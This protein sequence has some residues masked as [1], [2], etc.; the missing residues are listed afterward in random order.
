[1][2]EIHASA[3]YRNVERSVM[4][5]LTGASL[6]APIVP[7]GDEKFDSSTAVSTGFVR[8]SFQP[9]AEQPQGRVVDS[10]TTLQ[11]VRAHILLVCEVFAQGNMGGRS[12]VDAPDAIAESVAHAVR[13]LNVTVADWVTD[14]TGATPIAGCVCRF[15]QPHVQRVPASDGWQRRIISTEG[16]WFLRHAA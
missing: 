8:V 6:P 3:R 10:G 16:H 14:P 13:N 7:D 1:M 12:V 5:A 4:V 11:A 2:A 15:A 9:M